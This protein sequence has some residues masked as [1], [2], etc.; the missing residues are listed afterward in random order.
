MIQLTCK[1]FNAVI[2]ASAEGWSR[3]TNATKLS[4]IR[5]FQLKAR[6]SSPIDIS[7]TDRASV[8]KTFTKFVLRN[9]DRL[10]SIEW[11]GDKRLGSEFNAIYMKE[12]ED[13]K[14][15]V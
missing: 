15:V 3:V 10:R 11:E 12:R 9:A 2:K 14:S 13:R 4:K 1:R 8:S 5:L 7:T 6:K